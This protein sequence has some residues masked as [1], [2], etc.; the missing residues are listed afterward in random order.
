MMATH[1]RRRP[2]SR[3][4]LAPRRRPAPRRRSARDR[5]NDLIIVALILAVFAVIGAAQWVEAHRGI[6]LLVVSVAAAVA[7][8][9]GA[10]RGRGW[11]RA[12]RARR[13]AP[14]SLSAYQAATPGEF[15]HQTAALCRRDGCT[16]VT[17]VGGAGDLAADVLATLPGRHWW[18]V[19]LPRRR[20]ILIQCKRYQPGNLVGSEHV[21]RVNGTYRDIHRCD[22]AAIVTTSGYTRDATNL[23]RRVNIKLYGG[24][25]LEAWARGG[26][27]P[28]S[29]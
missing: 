6:A 29:R 14:T 11:Y 12:Y 10:R 3:S 4:R 17:V 20:R 23:A 5:R 1:T 24:P 28:W 27:P 22:I 25:E 13:T 15:E 16:D 18:Q 8:G 7:A 9:L 26:R 2:A 19:W 21:Q